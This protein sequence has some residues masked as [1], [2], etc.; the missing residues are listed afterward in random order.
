M[1]NPLKQV[2]GID[3]AKNELVVSLGRMNAD[4]SVD[5]FANKCFPNNSKGFSELINWVSKMMVK[6]VRVMYVMEATG[7]YHE[8]LAYFL[9][10]KKQQI[11]IVLPNKISS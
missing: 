8:A 5:V 10:D 6:D 4:T 3:V 11:S 9:F 7:I 1:I 2:A